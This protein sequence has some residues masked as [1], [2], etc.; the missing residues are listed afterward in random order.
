MLLVF[1]HLCF[2]HLYQ[3]AMLRCF[4]VLMR[5]VSPITF[6]HSAFLKSFARE[7]SVF[8]L[9]AQLDF[10]SLEVGNRFFFLFLF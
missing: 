6:G 1:D 9:G 7:R 3:I 4:S 2:V 10:S 5:K 8:W